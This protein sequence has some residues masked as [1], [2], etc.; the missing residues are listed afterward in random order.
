MSIVIYHTLLHK[1]NIVV[2]SRPKAINKRHAKK[3]TKFNNRQNKTERQEPKQIPKNIVHN[4]SSYTLSN[5]D[6]VAL[7]HG[8]DHQILI[9]NNRSNITS[10]FEYFYLMT[11]HIY[12]KFNLVREKLNLE[13]LVRNI[14]E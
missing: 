7:S 4:F 10:E 5:G 6:M 11:Y 1:I 9:R 8:L 13:T 14:A 12:L 3:L 2:K